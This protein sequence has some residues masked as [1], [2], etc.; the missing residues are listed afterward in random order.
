[1]NRHVQQPWP[2]KGMISKMSDPSGMRVWVIPLGKTTRPAKEISG[3]ER[4]LEWKEGEHGYHYMAVL[5]KDC[6]DLQP[7]VRNI[8]PDNLSLLPLAALR[9]TSHRLLQSLTEHSSGRRAS[10]LLLNTVSLTGNFFSVMSH[11]HSWDFLRASLWPVTF[12]I[13]PFLPSLLAQHLRALP[14]YASSCILPRHF[15]QYISCTSNPVSTTVFSKVPNWYTSYTLCSMK[16][17]IISALFATVSPVPSN[18]PRN[19]INALINHSSIDYMEG[20]ESRLDGNG[21][22][23]SRTHFREYWQWKRNKTGGWR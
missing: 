11:Q 6:P 20:V 15:P 4:N 14:A 7:T 9:H 12:L 23:K 17:G 2:E 22:N 1:M 13:Q 8:V 5:E 10:P 18:I 21:D 19:G 3:G 16:A